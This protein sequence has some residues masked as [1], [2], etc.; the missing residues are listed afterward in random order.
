[1][2]PR[3][4]RGRIGIWDPEK[5]GSRFDAECESFFVVWHIPAEKISIAANAV[6]GKAIDCGS[7]IG[8]LELE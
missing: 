3:G 6:D 5:V 8:G 2:S 7:G 4:R 1:L